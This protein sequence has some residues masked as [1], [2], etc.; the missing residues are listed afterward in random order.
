MS[1]LLLLLL[2]HLLLMML[3]DINTHVLVV[4]VAHV[5]VVRSILGVVDIAISSVL[6]MDLLLRFQL[7]VHVHLW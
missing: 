1:V 7:H 3:A 2:L 5:Y 6:Q 4:D